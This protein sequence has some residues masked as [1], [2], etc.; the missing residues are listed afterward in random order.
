MKRNS[1]IQQAGTKF[2]AARCPA[3]GMTMPLKE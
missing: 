1:L 3:G 2:F